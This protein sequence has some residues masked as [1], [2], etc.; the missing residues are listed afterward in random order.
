MLAQARHMHQGQMRNDL[1]RLMSP[2]LHGEVALALTGKW[3]GKIPFF[4]GVETE[5]LVLVATNLHAAVFAPGELTTPGF[6]C[7]IHKVRR[8]YALRRRPCIALAPLLTSFSCL[9]L[10]TSHLEPLTALTSYFPLVT[11]PPIRVWH[12][13]AGA[14]SRAA[15]H[16][17]TIAC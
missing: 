9:P 10:C 13:M 16:G 2:M 11:S 3:L 8:C 5:M 14:Y 12:S 1:L 17:G 7:V 6:L 4:K 15:A